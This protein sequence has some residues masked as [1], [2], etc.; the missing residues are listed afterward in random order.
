MANDV[1][2]TPD[3]EK[4][5]KRLKK[6]YKSLPDDVTVL[7]GQ[8]TVTPEMGDNLGSGLYKVRL[9]VKSKGGGKRGG[10]RV[11]TYL[12]RKK[13]KGT[14][15]YLLT[16]YDKGEQENID[17]DVLEKMVKENIGK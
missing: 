5:F 7:I 16:M 2:T 12:V 15:I 4:D 14:T 10:F 3:W 6:K 13:P 8:L 9:A 17:K 11:I 1:Q